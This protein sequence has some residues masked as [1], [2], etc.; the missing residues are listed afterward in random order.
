MSLNAHLEGVPLASEVVLEA[1]ED[2]ALGKGRGRRAPSGRGGR[3]G[4]RR[5]GGGGARNTDV[6]SVAPAEINEIVP[7]EQVKKRQK[8]PPVKYKV[9]TPHR[10]GDLLVLDG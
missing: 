6:D 8:K 3:G 2:V 1:S 5:G 7:I 4:R 10:T 9:D